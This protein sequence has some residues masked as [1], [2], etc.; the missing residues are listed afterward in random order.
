MTKTMLKFNLRSI[1]LAIVIASVIALPVYAASIWMS[2]DPGNQTI[3]QTASWTTYVGKEAGCPETNLKYEVFFGDGY[4]G[5]IYNVR[6]CYPYL[7][8][9]SFSSSGNY[10]QTWYAGQGSGSFYFMVYSY[11]HRL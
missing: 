9:H 6:A 8:S 11:V 10:T 5:V 3:N 2:V 4:Y 7:N 1:I